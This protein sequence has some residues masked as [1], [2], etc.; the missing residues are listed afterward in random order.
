MMNTNVIDTNIYWLPE[1]LFTDQAMQDEFLRCV[2]E[3]YDTKATAYDLED[4]RRAIKIEQPIGCENLNYFQGDYTLEHQL[5]DMDEAGVD[6]AIMKLPGCQEWL[7]LELARKF[8]DMQYEF[9]KASNGRM[10][11]LAIVPPHGDSETLAELD[12]CINELGFHG[13]QLSA[14]YGQYYLDDMRFRPFLKHVNE[15]NIPVYIHHTPLPVDHQ[16][17]LAYNNLRRSFG[18]CQDQITAIGRELFSGMFA[19]LPNL[20]MIHSMLGGGYFTYKEMLMPRDNGGGRFDTNTD[21]IRTYLEKNIFFELSHAQPWGTVNLE[22][23][24]KILGADHI[25]YGSSYPVK[26]SWLTGG[27]DFIRQLNITNEEKQ[28]ILHENAARLY[29]ID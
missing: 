19:E 13:L 3:E 22:A 16:S 24:V 10:I 2:P 27:P 25:I 9:A 29:D 11:P 17:L 5:Q 28:M 23:A 26:K 7:T 1:E 18:R 15:L 4:G 8:N 6:K 14:H 20:K 21:A 12:R